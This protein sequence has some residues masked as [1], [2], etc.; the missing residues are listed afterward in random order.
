VYCNA[1]AQSSRA[2][3]SAISACISKDHDIFR[4]YETAFPL[5]TPSSPLLLNQKAARVVSLSEQEWGSL[6]R[7]ADK[8][9]ISLPIFGS[10]SK[11]N[12]L[13]LEMLAGNLTHYS[14]VTVATIPAPL[15]SDSVSPLRQRSPYTRNRLSSPL[16]LTDDVH[17]RM[18]PL[19]RMVISAR[20]CLIFIEFPPAASHSSPDTLN[21]YDHFDDP[22]VKV[23][24]R[25]LAEKE[26]E[27]EEV[28]GLLDI[29]LQNEDSYFIDAV[30][31]DI[32]STDE[33]SEGFPERLSGSAA[34]GDNSG[35]NT[36]QGAYLMSS[37]VFPVPS[38]PPVLPPAEPKS[39]VISIFSLQLP[40]F[41]F[42][43]QALRSVVSQAVAV[44]NLSKTG[45][46]LSNVSSGLS[47][48]IREDLRSF[49]RESHLDNYATVLCSAMRDGEAV[50]KGDIQLGLDRCTQ[51]IYEVDISVMCRKRYLA[52]MTVGGEIVGPSVGSLCS[53]FENTLGRLLK[54]LEHENVFVLTN[55]TAAPPVPPPNAGGGG[56][57]GGVGDVD[58]SVGADIGVTSSSSS[59]VSSSSDRPA[60]AVRS[61]SSDP[62]T[63]ETASNTSNNIPDGA[64][65][66]LPSIR[67]SST[68]AESDTYVGSNPEVT[69]TGPGTPRTDF[70][71]NRLVEKIAHSKEHSSKDLVK[72]TPSAKVGESPLP[73]VP[74][75]K[76]PHSAP[77]PA[78][79]PPALLLVPIAQSTVI[80]STASDKETAR[81]RGKATFVRFLVVSRT[82]KPIQAVSQSGPPFSQLGTSGSYQSLATMASITTAN[83]PSTGAGTGGNGGTGTPGRHLLN[84]RLYREQSTHWTS[85]PSPHRP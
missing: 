62:Q 78:P 36:P 30:E 60:I 48:E 13:L 61:K 64:R 53:A 27:K 26:K 66:D 18:A 70:I 51:S 59:G 40:T 58:G 17:T 34:Q 25:P 50:A 82:E 79:A 12:L 11:T 14:A 15:Q 74:L 63:S 6:L 84:F 80:E 31:L 55:D 33:K 28:S 65:P 24:P 39:C 85:V 69:A 73:K 35:D 16:T 9:S 57:G 45:S 52:N 75:P 72:N 21:L 83:A 67:L 19:Y 38:E 46:G 37:I 2:I 43:D 10:S 1:G 47:E 22:T 8:E 71:D 41:R 81:D 3:E 44:P 32:D 5:M 4:L 20:N 77:E 54:G 68:S 49:I 56:G 42:V 76:S 7:Q 23:S 29:S